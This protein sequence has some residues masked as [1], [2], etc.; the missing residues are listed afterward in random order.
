MPP[1]KASEQR[2]LL[3]EQCGEE[4]LQMENELKE[5][6]HFYEVHISSRR[7]MGIEMTQGKRDENTDTCSWYFRFFGGEDSQ[8]VEELLIKKK[9][10][11]GVVLLII[12][13][14][15]ILLFPAA[16]LL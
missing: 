11:T 8:L 9:N 4:R 13:T 7:N 12:A 2:A 10:W 16:F 14:K 3:F 15:S 5:K 6:K 1:D